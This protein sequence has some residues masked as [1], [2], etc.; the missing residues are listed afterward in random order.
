M[1]KKVKL[2][3]KIGDWFIENNINMALT[4]KVIAEELGQEP[5]AVARAM[6]KVRNYLAENG[7]ILINKMSKGYRLGT[8]DE[9]KVEVDKA[10]R[11]SIAHMG[12]Y[13]KLIKA[14]QHVVDADACLGAVE[15]NK[16]TIARL[17]TYNIENADWL[18]DAPVETMASQMP[19]FVK[20][21]ANKLV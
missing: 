10:C 21:E 18:D 14:L 15:H 5:A 19:E 11:R 2:Y 6:S 4:V 8:P 20:D 3:K 7:Y 16:H 13:E 17:F 12:E 1:N 9:F